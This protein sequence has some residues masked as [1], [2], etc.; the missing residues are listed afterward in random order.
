MQWEP[1]NDA[2]AALLAAL[3]EDD[4]RRYFQ[5]LA[6]APLY[7]PIFADQ[8]GG[9][10]QRFVTWE[11]FG[12]TYLLVFTSLPALAAAVQTVADGYTTTSYRELRAKWPDPQ[13]RLAVNPGLPIDAWVEIEAL[14][15]AAAGTRPVTAVADVIRARRSTDPQTSAGLDAYLRSLLDA[16]VLVPVTERAAAGFVSIEEMPWRLAPQYDQPT[17]EVFTSV[18]GLAA[19][20]PPEVKCLRRR[21]AEVAASWPG[22]Q[23]QLVV[24][25]G[26]AVSFT[27]TGDKVPGLLL[28]LPDEADRPDRGAWYRQGGSGAE[29]A[30]FPASGE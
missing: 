27:L 30:E 19:G 3:L 5:V 11:L 17:I 22:E 18:E 13:W 25:P 9:G 14:A 10:G 6:T 23:Y 16:E 28:W 21:F 24:D 4:R 15:Q 29:P 2:E 1:A 20:C 12:H 7:L 8:G 26:S